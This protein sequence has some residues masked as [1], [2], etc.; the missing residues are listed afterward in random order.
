MKKFSMKCAVIE[1]GDDSRLTGWGS[2]F[3][4]WLPL[5]GTCRP[6]R[7]HEIIHNGPST[8]VYSVRWD[9]ASQE[10]REMAVKAILMGEHQLPK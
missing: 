7:I 4:E 6:V 10:E 8:S 9:K 5:C 2:V 1:T 3:V